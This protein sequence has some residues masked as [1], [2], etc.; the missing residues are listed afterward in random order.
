MTAL[1]HAMRQ[2]KPWETAPATAP[3]PAGT[4]TTSTIVLD[5][6]GADVPATMS[7]WSATGGRQRDAWTWYE[8]EAPLSESDAEAITSQGARAWSVESDNR[9][10]AAQGS[11]T[12]DLICTD[13][14]N[15]D[16]QLG[17]L[18]KLFGSAPTTSNLISLTNDG[19]ALLISAVV[20]TNAAEMMTSN[21]LLR[22]PKMVLRS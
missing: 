2:I 3:T 22:F 18:T 1:R 5:T 14:K 20:P 7:S 19:D 4:G 17:K 8:D 11:S 6:A 12:L 16:K 15:V 9:Q 21:L 10:T 13:L